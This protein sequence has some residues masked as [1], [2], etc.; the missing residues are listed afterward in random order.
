MTLQQT[1]TKF[2]NVLFEL[3]KSLKG[4]GYGKPQIIWGGNGLKNKRPW[5]EAKAKR[6][7]C[8][9]GIHEKCP[10]AEGD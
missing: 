6:R 3:N 1:S 7:Q 8:P 10:R 5:T 9:E 2:K 4:K